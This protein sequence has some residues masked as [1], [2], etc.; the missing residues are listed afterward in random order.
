[1]KDRADTERQSVRNQSRVG[2]DPSSGST[3]RRN[4]QDPSYSA[5]VSTGLDSKLS[6]RATLLGKLG[7]RP[8]LQTRLA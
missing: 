2:H 7:K 8:S 3:S 6:S 5:K 4:A 1:M